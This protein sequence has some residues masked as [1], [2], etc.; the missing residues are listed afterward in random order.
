MC[1]KPIA[2]IGT[3]KLFLRYLPLYP[4]LCTSSFSISS[5]SF[6]SY[7]CH[8]CFLTGLSLV[9]LGSFPVCRPGI[10]RFHVVK[11]G[12]EDA[13]RT[14][15]LPRSLVPLAQGSASEPSMPSCSPPYPRHGCSGTRNILVM[16][17]KHLRSPRP[18]VASGR[19]PSSSEATGLRSSRLC[20]APPSWPSS[21]LPKPSSPGAS[22]DIPRQQPHQ[23]ENHTVPHATSRGSRIPLSEQ[24]RAETQPARLLCPSPAVLPQRDSHAPARPSPPLLKQRSLCSPVQR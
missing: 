13:G 10:F 14:P 7:K 18:A 1:A 12:A 3:T 9:F 23:T 6:P 20:H 22:C 2:H 21:S 8:T 17:P 4:F 5:I 15:P 11:L 24:R 19:R 16:E